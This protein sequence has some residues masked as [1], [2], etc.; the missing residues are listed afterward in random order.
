[1][2]RIR[3]SLAGLRTAARDLPPP[4]KPPRRQRKYQNDVFGIENSQEGRRPVTAPA[5]WTQRSWP[6]ARLRARIP[7]AHRGGPELRASTARR[8]MRSLQP[9]ESSRP[10][11]AA[12]RYAGFGG[13]STLLN[14]PAALVRCQRR[15][16]RPIRSAPRGVSRRRLDACGK[17]RSSATP[18][19]PA[20]ERRHSSRELRAREAGAA[21][22]DAIR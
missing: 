15:A 13:G 1:M 8:G 4:R 3:H 16:A 6:E 22:S 20:F 9:S 5:C 10:S 7:R 11:A 18:D 17:S 2:S 14:S 19:R 21:R 12:V